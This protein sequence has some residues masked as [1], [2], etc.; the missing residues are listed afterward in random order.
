VV[1]EFAALAA[2]LVQPALRLIHLR[3]SFRKPCGA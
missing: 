3:L 1:L 2:N